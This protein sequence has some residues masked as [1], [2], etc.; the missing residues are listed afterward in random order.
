MSIEN[1][2]VTFVEQLR[3]GSS[4]PAV[5]DETFKLDYTD[6]EAVELELEH[7]LELVDSEGHRWR[8]TPEDTYSVIHL[9]RED[10]I[11][12]SSYES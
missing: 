7:V 5:L 9:V 3:I 6:P 12:W 2:T 1:D 4:M 10:K 8:V 11:D